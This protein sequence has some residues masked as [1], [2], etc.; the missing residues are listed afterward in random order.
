MSPVSLGDDGLPP[1]VSGAVEKTS[2]PACG[3]NGN[4]IISGAV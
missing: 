3:S 2:W 1:G 4:A